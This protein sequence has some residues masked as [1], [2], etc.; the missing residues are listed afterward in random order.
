MGAARDDHAGGRASAD[1]CAQQG[2]DLLAAAVVGGVRDFVEAV[3]QE[4]R[5]AAP[6][7]HPQL[8][9]EVLQAGAEDVIRHVAPE[10]F[11]GMFGGD[12]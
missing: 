3:E 4:H 7:E 1:E 9:D 12:R 10:L 5:L 2:L 11:F 8:A 6:E